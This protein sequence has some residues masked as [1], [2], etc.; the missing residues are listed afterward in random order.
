[1]AQVKITDLPEASSI[2]ANDLFVIVSSG[3]PYTTKKIL[4]SNVDA[5]QDNALYGRKNG[6]WQTISIPQPL[7]IQ[8]E[9]GELNDIP[10]DNIT[11]IQTGVTYGTV[12]SYW[13][14]KYFLTIDATSLLSDTS[15]NIE[16]YTT[17]NETDNPFNVTYI[18]KDIDDTVIYENWT[19]SNTSTITIPVASNSTQI[20][21]ITMFSELA[22]QTSADLGFYI[23]NSSDAY[24]GMSITNN[25]IVA[26]RVA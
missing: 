24:A 7:E 5:P 18:C 4:H 1:M 14:I 19:F 20:L 8:F 9:D 23:T 15:I 10:E 21:E 11:Q 3:N 26:Q 6:G 2:S 16:G 22:D 17:I 12:G 25:K 13:M